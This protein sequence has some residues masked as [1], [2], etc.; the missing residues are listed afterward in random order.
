MCAQP[1]PTGSARLLQSRPG[2]SRLSTWRAGGGG[3]TVVGGRLDLG[4]A[5]CQ[6]LAAADQ[7][8][9]ELQPMRRR[10]ALLPQLR[11]N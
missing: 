4:R 10:G 1:G 6:A 2:V 9:L 5:P 7:D 11:S 3:C 8:L